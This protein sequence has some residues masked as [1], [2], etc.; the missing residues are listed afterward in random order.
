MDYIKDIEYRKQLLEKRSF[1]Q[2]LTKEERFWLVTNP[3]F[4][5]W[6]GYPFYNKDVLN[7]KLDILYSIHIKII[8]LTD[9]TP[10]TITL[11][12]SG[13]KGELISEEFLL[14]IDGNETKKKTTK[15]L[16]FNLE[17]KKTD[18]YVNFKSKLGLLDISYGC[19]YYDDNVKLFKTESSSTGNPSFAMMK[20]I[21]SE[22]KVQ[23]K[24]KHPNSDTYDMLVFE[25]EMEP[26]QY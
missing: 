6:Y 24:C 5:R 2:Q 12:V 20:E 4:N 15:V 18:Y 17:N 11:G 14:D 16:R 23:Y 3:V 8:E 19:D 7:L 21:I 26:V 10:V 9:R 13:N 25:I 22:G 1:G